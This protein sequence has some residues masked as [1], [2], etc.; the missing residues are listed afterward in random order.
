MGILS[1]FG[2]GGKILASLRKLFGS[3]ALSTATGKLK[4]AQDF[5][6]IYQNSLKLKFDTT[7]IMFNQPFDAAHSNNCSSL[8]GRN[9]EHLRN[10]S[11]VPSHIVLHVLPGIRTETR[12]INVSEKT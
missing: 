4:E 8:S 12:N 7:I 1:A 11:R 10:R 5:E 6:K 9:R 3:G 2:E